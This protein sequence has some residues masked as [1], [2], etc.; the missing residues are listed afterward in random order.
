MRRGLA[1]VTSLLL[2]PAIDLAK[3]EGQDRQK[4]NF[5]PCAEVASPVSAFPYSVY[6]SINKDTFGVLPLLIPAQTVENT[7][8]AKILPGLEKVVKIKF[9]HYPEGFN[10]IVADALDKKRVNNPA[11]ADKNWTDPQKPITQDSIQRM[12]INRI[13]IEAKRGGISSKSDSTIEFIKPSGSSLS[14][15]DDYGF[16][17]ATPEA[18][19]RFL[20]SVQKGDITF[21]VKY[22]MP[23][24]TES[25][26]RY[27]INVKLIKDRLIDSKILSKDQD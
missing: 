25:I 16:E 27:E 20:D 11:F 24:T 9:I 22:N 2:I 14:N 19:Q 21:Y 6:S 8:D 3:S 23:I 4:Q 17:F 26:S 5:K 12:S 1:F 18:A 7:V 15:M 13:T 10:K